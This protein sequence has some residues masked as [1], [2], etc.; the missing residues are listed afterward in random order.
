MAEEETCPSQVRV[1][2][3]RRAGRVGRVSIYA[4]SFP[5]ETSGTLV[6]VLSPINSGNA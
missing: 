5:L 3:T 6:E 2:R 1:K 4:L